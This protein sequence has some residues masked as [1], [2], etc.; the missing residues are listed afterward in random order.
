MMDVALYKINIIIIILDMTGE[1][2][3]YFQIATDLMITEVMD[4]Y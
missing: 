3:L 2:W 4:V 1:Y